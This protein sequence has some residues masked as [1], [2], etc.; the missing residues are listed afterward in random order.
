MASAIPL[1]L[2]MHSC[3]I[4]RPLTGRFVEYYATRFIPFQAKLFYFKSHS[5]AKGFQCKSFSGG[6]PPA[7]RLSPPREESSGRG[8]GAAA[9]PSLVQQQGRRRPR[10]AFPQGSLGCY[11]FPRPSFVGDASAPSKRHPDGVQSEKARSPT[12]YM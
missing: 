6:F 1:R 4:E 3:Y 12:S 9:A 7:R 11:G 10:R 2:L 8:A 5:S